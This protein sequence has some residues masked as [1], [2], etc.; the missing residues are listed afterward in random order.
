MILLM[1]LELKKYK[2]GGYIVGVIAA[3]LALA[4]IVW[5]L[6]QQ[7]WQDESI[8][9]SPT[10]A[11]AFA[12]I[13]AMV[14]ITF[15]IFAA[16]LMARM[17]VGEYTSKTISLL[18]GYPIDRRKVLLSK[19]LLVSLVTFIVL[20]VSNLIISSAFCGMNVY[21]DYIKEPLT[22]EILYGQTV[23]M[24]VQAGLTTAIN[25]I[26]FVLGMIRKSATTTVTSSFVIEFA[27]Y[28]TNNGLTLSVIPAVTIS[29]AAIGAAG[30]Y[31][32]ILKANRDDVS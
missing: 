11:V 3:N 24:F 2:F 22:R 21:Y 9:S 6:Q 25:W 30:A 8:A 4:G 18:F 32:T 7:G 26:P 5:T 31:W 12:F 19:L 28:A 17:I 14:S 15:G 10:Y 29:L 1:K 20:I 13:R 27:I 23:E 16:V